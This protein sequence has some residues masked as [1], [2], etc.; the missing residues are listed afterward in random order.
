MQALACRSRAMRALVQRR[1]MRPGARRRLHDELDRCAILVDAAR[2]RGSTFIAESPAGVPSP[3]K[4]RTRMSKKDEGRILVVDDEESIRR[5]LRLCLEGAGFEVTLAPAGEAAV[6]AARRSPPD[7]AL[8]DLRL[9]GMDGIAVTRALAHEAPSTSVVLMTAYATIDNA[10][11]AMRAGASDYLPKPFTPAQVLHVV[12]KALEAARVRAEL[13]ELQRNTARGV[14]VRLQTSSTAMKEALAVASRAAPTEATILLLGETGTGKGVIAR[15]VHALSPRAARPFVTL[16]CAVI[17]PNLVENE[18]FGHA[19]GAFTGADGARV[20]HVEA[21]GAGTLFLD[22]VG[23]LPR[24][25]QGKLLRLLEEHEYVR[26]GDTEP[27]RSE[28]R[29][30]AAT[31]RDLKAAVAAG[32]F[33]E[34]LFYRLDVVTLRVPS[35]RDR[36]EDVPA[37]AAAVVADLSTTHRR[38]PLRIDPA[39]MAA[40]TSYRWPGNV[41]E[42]ANVLER[43]VILAAGDVITPD[44]LPEELRAT[45]PATLTVDDES[46]EA[47]ERRH[48]TAVLARHPTLDAAA[49]ALRIDPSTLYRKRERYGLL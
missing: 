33:R 32:N 6:T 12:R 7:L 30:I 18:L 1:T 35:L 8:V 20:G 37:L 25:A 16:N 36:R 31:H 39:A 26:V 29:V 47:A 15:H 43:A 45:A 38:E 14:R 4:E 10:V 44:L 27:R 13:A 40:L 5:M 46:L 23:D 21:A 9:G 34:D 17:S 41:R 28:A 22:E 11:D 3:E 42:L 49:K 48:I 24:E 2:G 19:K